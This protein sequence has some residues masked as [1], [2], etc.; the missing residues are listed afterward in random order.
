MRAEEGD[1]SI[2]DYVEE[3]QQTRRRL[4]RPSL[5]ERLRRMAGRLTGSAPQQ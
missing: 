2:R 5:W 4:D 3:A 1:E